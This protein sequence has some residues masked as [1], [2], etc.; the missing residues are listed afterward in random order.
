LGFNFVEKNELKERQKVKSEWIS[1]T[2]NSH[3][4]LAVI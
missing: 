2:A 1:T 4:E 3:F